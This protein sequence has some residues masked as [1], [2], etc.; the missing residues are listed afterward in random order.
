MGA[1]YLHNNMT[2]GEISPAL[3]SRVGID[4]YNSSV[5]MARNVVISPYGGLRRRQGLNKHLGAFLGTGTYR[6]EKFIA[7]EDESYVMVFEP[8][9]VRIYKQGNILKAEVPLI[10]GGV[11][12][13]AT[14]EAIQSFDYAQ[15]LD[16][17]IIVNDDFPPFRLIRNALDDTDWTVEAIEL[18][19]SKYSFTNEP[20]PS[21]KYLNTGQ[22]LEVNTI[23]AG[24]IVYNLD[25]DDLNGSDEAFYQAV[26]DLTAVRLDNEDY[27][28]TVKW[29]LIPWG[30]DVFSATR[31]YPS[32]VTFYG[33]RL[34]FGGTKSLGTAIFGS[35]INGYFDF[36]LGTGED[37]FGIFDII[38]TGDY[39]KI[40]NLNTGRSLQAFTTTR[41]FIN[42]AEF[43]TPAD[44]SWKEQTSYGS[45]RIKPINIDGSSLFVD[46]AGRSIRSLIYSLDEDSYVS[47]T[48]SLTANHLLTDVKSMDSVRG[49]LAD[50]SDFLYVVN[51]D[52][53]VAVWNTNRLENISGW[54][55]WTTQGNFEDVTVLNK[56]VIFL[57]DRNGSKYLEVLDEDCYTDH[58]TVLY[59]TGTSP[60]NVAHDGVNTVYGVDNIIH[61]QD[62]TAGQIFE[63]ATNLEGNAGFMEMAMTLDYTI[64]ED[65]FIN[66][67]T[68]L[69][70]VT[71]PR[72]AERAEIGLNFTS[73]IQTL[74][75]A[76]DTKGGNYINKKKRLSRVTLDYLDTIGGTVNQVDNNTRQFVA[77]LDSPLQKQTA[78]K[79]FRFLGYSKRLAVTVEQR[80]PLPLYVRSIEVEVI[81]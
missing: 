66:D 79:E 33:Q 40:V 52:G 55:Q 35:K 41:E 78:I 1:V 31:G 2:G 75:E 68:G 51:N 5:A 58:A 37:D 56:N 63:V 74:P 27:S 15:Y 43:I 61:T 46:S 19:T 36:R 71:L 20:Q 65:V 81:Y 29:T 25:G 9:K 47:P 21:Y 8:G 64:Q 18:Q 3:H 16:T 48:I 23:V 44:S 59:G 38:E 53:S 76:P 50:V 32:T 13:L 42:T 49:T 34:W 7:S 62:Q 72:G 69:N 57:V 11:T 67:N 60:D 77:Q 10:I 4:K 24:D 14:D 28:D 80:Q 12:Y 45:K 54:S 6:I 26:S 70:T 22:P 39:N 17:S 30:E 73:L